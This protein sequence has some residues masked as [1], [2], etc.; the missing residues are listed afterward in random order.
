MASEHLDDFLQ[1]HLFY[2]L[3]FSSYFYELEI[4]LHNWSI[5][6]QLWK[7]Y[8][9]PGVIFRLLSPFPTSTCLHSVTLVFSHESNQTNTCI[10]RKKIFKVLQWAWTSYL[11][12]LVCQSARPICSSLHLSPPPPNSNHSWLCRSRGISLRLSLI[13][14]IQSMMG[15][16]LDNIIPSQ[17]RMFDTHLHPYQHYFLSGIPRNLGTY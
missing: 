14:F 2:E 3:L 11:T 5:L 7:H 4:P 15:Q 9:W 17:P 1:G 13:V 8:L 12:S 16:S 6:L 10:L